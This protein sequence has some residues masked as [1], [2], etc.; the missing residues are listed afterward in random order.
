MWY[1]TF[2]DSV[3]GAPGSNRRLSEKF[4]LECKNLED[5]SVRQLHDFWGNRWESSAKVWQ[6]YWRVPFLTRSPAGAIYR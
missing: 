4:G 5:R 6:R 2:E 1:S 3:L